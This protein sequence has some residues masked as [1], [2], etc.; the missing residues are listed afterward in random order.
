M[1]Q[2]NALRTY[3]LAGL[4]VALVDAIDGVIY[5]G[6]TAGLNP[7]MVLQYI[8]T[9]I[10]GTAAFREGLPAA[11][12][13][14]G[15]HFFISYAFTAILFAIMLSSPALRRSWTVVGPAWGALVYLFMTFV[16]LPHSNVAYTPLTPL[17]FVH[18]IAGHALIVGLLPA[19]IIQRFYTLDGLQS[20]AQEP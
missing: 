8:A 17:A 14:L 9:G 11:I 10:L 1:L 20:A 13:G 6:I 16:A 7:V 5:F 19:Y 15:A 3:A 4:A 18:G 2:Q 12:L